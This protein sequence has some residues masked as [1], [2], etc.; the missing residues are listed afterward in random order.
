MDA[1]LLLFEALLLFFQNVFDFL[2][3]REKVAYY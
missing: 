2:T 1:G 3:C